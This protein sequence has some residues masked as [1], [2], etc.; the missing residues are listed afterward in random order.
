M[1]FGRFARPGKAG[2]ARAETF[3]PQLRWGRWRA[4][5]DGVASRNPA[6]RASRWTVARCNSWFRKW[7]RELV[8]SGRRPASSEFVRRYATHELHF[9]QSGRWRGPGR[10]K[11]GRVDERF[12]VRFAL[13]DFDRSS[14]PHPIRRHSP[15]K[16]GVFRRPMAPPSPG[17][18]GRGPR[19]ELRC[20]NSAGW[21]RGFERRSGMTRVIR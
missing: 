16:T 20:V 14:G 3:L 15:S 5:P 9:R 11:Q 10:R 17:S 1:L 12:A 8:M 18:W 7:M 2:L 4:A 19:D 21:R 13:S 6:M